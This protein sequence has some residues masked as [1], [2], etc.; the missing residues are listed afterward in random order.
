MSAPDRR[1]HAY[2]VGLPK[3]GTHSLDGLFQANY[4]SAHEPERLE[5]IDQYI[6]SVR[7]Q[8]SPEELLDFLRDRDRKLDLE[9]DAS[10]YNYLVLPQLVELFPDAK[11]F[12]LVRDCL[13]WVESALRHTLA[14]ISTPY[15]L[16]FWGAWLRV[17]RYQH[18]EEEA[19]LKELGLFPL[20]SYLEGWTRFL[21][22]VHQLVPDG[23][24]LA[25]RTKEIEASIPQIAEFLDIPA[26]TL[27]AEQAHLYKAKFEDR[28]LEKLDSDFVVAMAEEAC[29][30]V[31]EHFFPGQPIR[32]F[33]SG[34]V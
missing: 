8:V 25:V 10:V 18:E 5:L 31:M 19:Q 24:L 6:A 15:E 1:F 30:K 11:Y 20:R 9:M 7:K 14:N 3:A 21:H 26:S 16:S 13:G 4:R 32:S 17:K 33:W 22:H 29:G 27:D 28:V 23:Q 2:C 34:E 12:V